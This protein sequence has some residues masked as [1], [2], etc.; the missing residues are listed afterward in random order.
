M[1]W[2][3]EWAALSARIRGIAE[4]AEFY[5]RTT[6]VRSTDIYS[7]LTYSLLPQARSIHSQLE[8]FAASYSG[9]L[10]SAAEDCLKRF[11]LLRPDVFSNTD[12]DRD[13][14]IQFA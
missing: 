8:S 9:T 7:V 12:S 3:T 1:N 14:A 4:A 10:P 2:R 11:L 13:G 5:V 6:G